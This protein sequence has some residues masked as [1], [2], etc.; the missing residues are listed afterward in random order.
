[1]KLR[2][3]FIALFVLLFLCIEAFAFATGSFPLRITNNQSWFFHDGGILQADGNPEFAKELIYSKGSDMLWSLPLSHYAVGRKY[4]EL[5]DDQTL[6]LLYHDQQNRYFIERINIDGSKVQTEQLPSDVSEAAMFDEGYVYLQKNEAASAI[7]LTVCDWHGQQKSW[8]LYRVKRMYVEP[9]EV[10]GGKLYLEAHY[11]D[12][13]DQPVISQLCIS[14]DGKSAWEYRLNDLNDPLIKG[15]FENNLGGISLLV[16]TSKNNDDWEL[17]LIDLDVNGKEVA[18]HRVDGVD[19]VISIQLIEREGADVFRIWG[20]NN[21][22]IIT[23]LF[24]LQG[25]LLESKSVTIDCFGTCVRY[26]NDEVYVIMTDIPMTHSKIIPFD[27]LM[28]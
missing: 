27:V 7:T 23:I 14:G 8:P 25:Q 17:T 2:I 16:Q 3:R 24:T 5:I 15:K 6:V 13:N 18:R 26:I 10:L 12:I 19:P 20:W 11:R 21:G 4:C 9:V 22:K 1:M 28:E